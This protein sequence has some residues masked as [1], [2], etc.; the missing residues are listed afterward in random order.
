MKNPTLGKAKRELLF[1]GEKRPAKA[2]ECVMERD[3]DDV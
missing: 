1:Q 2:K 3:D